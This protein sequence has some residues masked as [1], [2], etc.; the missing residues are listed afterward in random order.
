MNKSVQIVSNTPSFLV[1]NKPSGLPTVPL[2]ANPDAE[3][4]LKEVSR[5][6]PEVLQIN[7]PNPWEGGVIHRLDTATSG[8]VL[9]AR[10][11][12]AYDFFRK[13]QEDGKIVKDYNAVSSSCTAPSE[14]F[15]EYSYGDL[16]ES[17]RTVVVS[18]LFRPY[19]KDRKEVRPVC[20]DSS[21]II[22]KKAGKKL[23]STEITY[24]GDGLFRCRIRAGFRHQI[25]V[26]LAWSGHPI[27]GDALYGGKKAEVLKLDAFRL[28][29]P[30]PETGIS[31]I[32]GSQN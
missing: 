14:G 27:D 15:P 31:V 29:F 25:R 4:L 22:K 12:A 20:E 13:A 2:K 1:V 10:T 30:D 17:G 5:S 32:I 9:I 6:Y 21:E 23:Y 18:S 3:S 24:V 8:L 28:I 11:Q 19:G 7:S 16:Y 26:H